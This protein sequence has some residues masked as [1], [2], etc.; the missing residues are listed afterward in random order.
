MKLLNH[1]PHPIVHEQPL[2][3]RTGPHT[4]EEETEDAGKEVPMKL[5]NGF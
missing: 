2:T 5:A 3:E 1:M 4:L